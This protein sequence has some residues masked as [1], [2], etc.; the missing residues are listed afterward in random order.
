MSPKYKFSYE[1]LKY[2]AQR[3]CDA[4]DT[5]FLIHPHYYTVLKYFANTTYFIFPHPAYELFATSLCQTINRR[6]PA[7]PTHRRLKDLLR[8]FS[9]KN[10]LRTHY[11]SLLLSIQ[12]NVINGY[13]LLDDLDYTDEEFSMI[14]EDLCAYEFRL[15]RSLASPQVTPPPSPS[16]EFRDYLFVEHTH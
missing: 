11:E 12:T 7:P 16:A 2:H 6:R 1:T 5:L 4:C 3:V 13:V 10:T 14:W 9:P 8:N 15:P